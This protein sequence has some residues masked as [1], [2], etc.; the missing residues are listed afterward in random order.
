MIANIVTW[1]SIKVAT[2]RLA[3]AGGVLAI[4][5]HTFRVMISLAIEAR[6]GAAVSDGSAAIQPCR[7][8]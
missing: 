4:L 3:L 1:L 2:R 7:C 6:P 5:G 8:Q